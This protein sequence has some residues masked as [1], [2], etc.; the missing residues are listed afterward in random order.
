[1]NLPRACGRAP[2]R[3]EVGAAARAASETRARGRGPSLVSESGGGA[4]DTVG[5]LRRDRV[6]LHGG[7]PRE[8]SDRP[9]QSL[10][11]GPGRGPPEPGL[12]F[13]NVRAPA[14]GIILG[15]GPV[16]DVWSAPPDERGH[17]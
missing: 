3:M 2:P 15:Q 6:T 9:P 4:I 1:M 10:P 7:A 12:G 8:P 14:R 13:P 17:G 5:V 16:D 11:E